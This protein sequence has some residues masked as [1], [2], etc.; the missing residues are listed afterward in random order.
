M[1]RPEPPRSASHRHLPWLIAISFFMGLLDATILNTALP[2]MAL[3]LGE[4]PLHMQAVVVV[5][6]LTLAA[7]MPAS[8]WLADRFGTRHIFQLALA[9]F[10]LGSLACALS[11]SLNQL[12][13][14]RV[15]QA[16]GGALLMPVGRLAVLKLYPPERLIRVLA[17]I[18]L[19]GLLGPLIGPVLGGWMVEIASWHWIFLINLPM[20][21]L[22]IVLA[23]RW[24][25][26]LRGPLAPFD[27]RGFVLFGASIT[28]LSWALQSLGHADASHAGL[29]LWA[30]AGLLC[31]AGYW[32]HAARVPHPLFSVELLRLPTFGLALL[33][34]LLARLGSGAMPF[35]TP[36]YLQVGLG[37]SPSEAG[38][39]MVPAALGAMASKAMVEAL[40]RRYGYRTVLTWNTLLLGVSIASFGHVAAHFS[41]VWIWLHLGLFGVFNS[42]QFTSMNTLTLG[43]LGPRFASSGNTFF[44]V[45]VQLSMGMGVALGGGLLGLFGDPDLAARSPAL[46]AAFH[47]TYLCVG[48]ATVLAAAVF[49]RVP[50]HRGRAQ[51]PVAAG[52]ANDA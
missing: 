18:T 19:P 4:S 13:G 5:Y 40:V 33:G 46:H 25:P 49:L 24:M 8:G 29:L 7:V 39:T 16:V 15:L 47:A 28:M 21:L 50:R 17:F 6:L 14:A 3:D 23:F 32:L 1:N 48:T 45:V 51:Q 41:I 43:T 11:S 12:I 20:G 37:Y 35:L 27:L 10:C 52:A 36:V 9:L 31:L 38:M 26:N 30:A 34:N 2:M 42:L 44:A 22:G